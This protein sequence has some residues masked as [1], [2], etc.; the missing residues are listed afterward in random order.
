MR[1]ADALIAW[2]CGTKV[3]GGD[4]EDHDEGLIIDVLHDWA[5]VAW[6]NGVRRWTPL[7]DLEVAPS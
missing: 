1:K 6:D 2:H 7:A 4:G 5:K 3:Q